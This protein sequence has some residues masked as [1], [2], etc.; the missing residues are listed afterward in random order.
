MSIRLG[1][2]RKTVRT[3]V[4]ISA[5]LVAFVDSEVAEGRAES[6]NEL[7]NDA[8]GRELRRRRSEEFDRQILAASSDPEL[9]A[10]EDEVAD[11]FEGID[12]DEWLTLDK[13]AARYPCE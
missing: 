7:L 8:L 12:R 3:T 1:S 5:D 13:D 10:M 4:T 2:Q 11:D 9:L 6:R